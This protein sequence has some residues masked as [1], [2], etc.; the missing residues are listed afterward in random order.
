VA[1]SVTVEVRDRDALVSA[2]ARLTAITG[3]REVRRT[4]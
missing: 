4:G 3:V 2:I 1:V